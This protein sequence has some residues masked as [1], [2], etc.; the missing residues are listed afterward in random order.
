MSI[1]N[2][3]IPIPKSTITLSKDSFVSYSKGILSSSVCTTSQSLYYHSLWSVQRLKQ[4]AERV[5]LMLSWRF[6]TCMSIKYVPQLSLSIDLFFLKFFVYYHHLIGSSI[7]KGPH[8]I[9][10]AQIWV[11][12][13]LPRYLTNPSR[14]GRP[15]IIIRSRRLR[16]LR[17]TH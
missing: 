12:R 3:S 13:P 4:M 8:R 7:D 16:I 9:H 11:K 5:I 17:A 10:T 6:W 15:R 14:S 1:S 2:F